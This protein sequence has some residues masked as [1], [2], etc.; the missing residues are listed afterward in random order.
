MEPNV[1]KMT[2]MRD[3]L[4]VVFKRKA[5]IIAFFL[6]TICAVAAGTLL[7]KP[8]YEAVSQI[9]VKIGRENLYVPALPSSGPI[10]NLNQDEQ[11]HTEIEIL[12]SLHI[13]QKV[14]ESVG[15][16]ALYP[17][18]GDAGGLVSGLFS[19]ARAHQA[20][21]E[22]AVLAFQKDLTV[23]RIKKSNVIEARYRN[24]DP[25]V[26][27]RAVNTLVASYLER[28]LQVHKTGES[29]KFF[30]EQAGLLK[31]RLEQAEARLETFKRQHTIRSLDEERT[32]LLGKEA[33][34]RAQMNDTVSRI[35]ETRNR[36][37]QLKAQLAATAKTIPQDTQA[38]HSPYVINTL[39]G[40]LVE[41]QLKEKELLGKY[42]E[43]N[44]LVQNVREEIRI[45]REKLAEVETKRYDRVSSGP[46][47]TYQ[48]LQRE[49]LTNQAELEALMGK[50]E[51]Q[52]G[53]YS[54]YQERLDK[55]N[56]TEVQ[57]AQL[58]EQVEVDRKNYHLYLSK[59]E[60]SR[61]SEAMDK[62]KIANVTQIQ[63]AMKPLTPVGPKVALNLALGLFLG[64][65]G[66]LGLAFFMEYL[67]DSIDAPDKA[68]Q[69]MGV[70]V[71]A[72]IPELKKEE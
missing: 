36:I 15:P 47:P 28:H 22:K 71:L 24:P 10:I 49:L 72:S 26:S 64:V 23:E 9:L 40:R 18:L 69:A 48:N 30:E 20:P 44:R 39:Q 70:P 42:T 12:T 11:I 55:L 16:L 17:G 46:N 35:S 32:I 29:H 67:D 6:A 14:V 8:S 34:L 58:K 43:Q 54:D 62:E 56:R 19:G 59:F 31:E 7:S 61:I 52:K 51:T 45:V 4:A 25:D 33:D 3:V 60:E 65:F 37:T 38:E 57:L 13:A 2:G 53:H 1:Q 50:S 5:Q 63:V 21:M 66:G 27:A 68:E 41:L